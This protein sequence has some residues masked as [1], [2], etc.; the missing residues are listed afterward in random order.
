VIGT[1]WVIPSDA[2]PFWWEVQ[3]DYDAVGGARVDPATAHPDR[4]K[5]L[6]PLVVRSGYFEEPVTR[7]RLFTV[8]FTADAYAMN[9]GTQSGIKEFEPDS[10]A[11]LVDRIRRRIDTSGGTIN[12]HL[13]AVLT[14]TR[15][16]SGAG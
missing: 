4:V 13:L 11:E 2:D 15:V 10:R 5:D 6:A 16:R 14:V 7:R 3:D 8:T 12:A 9:L 1:P